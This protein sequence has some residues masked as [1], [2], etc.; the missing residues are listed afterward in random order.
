MPLNP[1][2]YLNYCRFDIRTTLKLDWC[3]RIHTRFQF[4]KTHLQTCPLL[5]LVA[6]R[7]LFWAQNMPNTEV[8]DRKKDGERGVEKQPSAETWMHH[9]DFETHVCMQWDGNGRCMMRP[10]GDRNTRKGNHRCLSKN[11][12]EKISYRFYKWKLG[13]SLGQT[14]SE[15]NTWPIAR[16]KMVNSALSD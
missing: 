2:E 3:P 1:F 13:T 11:D 14:I 10:Q 4:P 16:N 5:R 8:K 7:A 6:Y 12:P 9:G 15:W